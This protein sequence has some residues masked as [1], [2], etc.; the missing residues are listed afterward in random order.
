V[1]GSLIGGTPDTDW[2]LGANRVYRADVTSLVNPNGNG[3]Y[4]F[5]GLNPA[6]PGDGQGASLV[7]F[8]TK[9]GL[10]LGPP[11]GPRSTLVLID[12]AF[13][14]RSSGPSSIS[15]LFGSLAVGRQPTAVEAHFGIGDGQQS[16]EQWLLAF[17]GTPPDIALTGA[18]A[19]SGTDGPAWD[20]Q[21]VPV[22]TWFVPAGTNFLGLTFATD[23]DS[24]LW[25]YSALAVNE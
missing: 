25:S 15:T 8:W 6:A 20:D 17:D 2:S 16:P 24:L 19:F 12:G 3:T 4:S 18:N 10:F 7:V 11:R 9:P 14:A 22:P 13:E 5:S 21:T 23:D 1:T